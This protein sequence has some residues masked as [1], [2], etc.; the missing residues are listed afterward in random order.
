MRAWMVLGLII[1]V[2]LVSGSLPIQNETRLW[3]G[4][5][6]D[7]ALVRRMISDRTCGSSERY[8]DA[9]RAALKG[10]AVGIDLRDDFTGAVARLQAHTP[11]EQLGSAWGRLLNRLLR[12]FDP[13]ARLLPTSQ[14]MS[15]RA[16]AGAD[17]VGLGIVTVAT[18]KG[19]FV[20]EVF[21]PSAAGA[22]GLRA[23]DRIAVIDGVEVGTGDR[24]RENSLRLTGDLGRKIAL[25]IWRGGQSREVTAAVGPVVRPSLETKLIAAGSRLL[26]YVRVYRFRD[27]ACEALRERLRDL[28][29]RGAEG[30]ILDLRGNPG[31]ILSEGKCVA[32][33]FLGGHT[34]VLGQ[35]R[36]RVEIPEELVSRPRGEDDAIL[37]EST[38]ESG[39]FA[40][41]PMVALIDRASASAAEVVAAALQDYGRALILGERS[42]GKGSAQ[43]VETLPGHPELTVIHTESLFY[44]PSGAA[45]QLSGVKPDVVVSQDKEDQFIGEG[46]PREAGLGGAIL[47][48]PSSERLDRPSADM[49]VRARTVGECLRRHR[50]DPARRSDATMQAA[51]AAFDCP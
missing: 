28:R 14:A 3:A 17:Y 30:W 31:G 34:R 5:G 9:C 35:R 47:R 13:H 40:S 16:A 25:R 20:H 18:A 19:L 22:A 10:A 45:I 46:I 24:A 32:G 6:V 26:G 29:A 43:V 27:G 48:P 33:V 44:R 7:A 2:P 36:V 51:F 23:G 1:A 50:T 12:E 8:R 21:S 11:K 37:W 39:E 42:F 15:E 38:W 41:A 4:S 49:R